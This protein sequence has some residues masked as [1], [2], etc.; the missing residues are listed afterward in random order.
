ME[1]GAEHMATIRKFRGTENPEYIQAMREKRRSNA[2][3]LHQDKRFKRRRTRSTQR[4]TAIK[5]Y[6]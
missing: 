6:F 1:G 5:D 3:G 2:A 4:K